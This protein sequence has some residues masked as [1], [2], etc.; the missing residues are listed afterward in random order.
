MFFNLQ[1]MFH[2]NLDSS[3]RSR[4]G[5]LNGES[6]LETNL[7]LNEFGTTFANLHFAKM[8]KQFFRR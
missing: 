6:P 7:G 3:L 8:H 2:L 4:R 5:D 1:N